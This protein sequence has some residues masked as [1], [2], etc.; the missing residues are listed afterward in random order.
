MTLLKPPW[1]NKC[2]YS[3]RNIFCDISGLAS[4]REEKKVS[5]QVGIICIQTNDKCRW[6]IYSK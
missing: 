5:F 2:K 6:N 3:L 4:N 1:Y